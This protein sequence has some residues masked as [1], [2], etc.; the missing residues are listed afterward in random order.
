MWGSLAQTA[1]S[2]LQFVHMK[3]LKES[4][5][6]PQKEGQAVVEARD[7]GRLG[8]G[9]WLSAASFRLP[10]LGLTLLVRGGMEMGLWFWFEPISHLKS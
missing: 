9:R 1:L 6:C 8:L 2:P 4:Y 3:K 10:A 7:R 5:V